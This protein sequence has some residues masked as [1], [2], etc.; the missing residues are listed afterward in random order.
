MVRIYPAQ[1]SVCIK[2]SHCLQQICSLCELEIYKNFLANLLLTEMCFIVVVTITLAQLFTG[3]SEFSQI[4][5]ICNNVTGSADCQME[6]L[7]NMQINV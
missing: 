4:K 6:N 2:Q 5:N 3:R 7:C 1:V